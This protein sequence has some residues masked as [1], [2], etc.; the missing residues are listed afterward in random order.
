MK[1]TTTSFPY[2]KLR[3]NNIHIQVKKAI[4]ICASLTKKSLS[5]AFSS[6]FLMSLV[7]SAIIFYGGQ[8][9]TWLV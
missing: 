9:M 5:H 4:D 3:D 2:V 6:I 1:A 7:A 8:Q